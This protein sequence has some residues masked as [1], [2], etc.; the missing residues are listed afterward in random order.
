MK[1]KALRSTCL[2][3]HSSAVDANNNSDELQGL[4]FRKLW[5]QFKT[6]YAF[7]LLAFGAP[8]VCSGQ[9]QT[10]DPI[11]IH[12]LIDS[13][14]LS[15]NTNYVFPEK[16]KNISLYLQTQLKKNAYAPNLKDPQKLAEQIESD[17][18]QVHHDPHLR[19][20]YDPNFSDEKHVKPS[21]EEITQSKKYWKTQNYSFPKVEILPGNVGYLPIYGFVDDIKSAKPTI[22]AALQFLANTSAILID[23]RENQGGSPELV[24]QI[25]SY[26]F[27]EKTHMNDLINR[28]AKDTTVFYADPAKSDSLN[29]TM[30]VYILTSHKTFS[31]AEDF[32]YGMQKAKRATIVGEITGGGA[33]PQMPFSIGQGFVCSIPFARSYNTVTK[34]DWEGTGVIPDAKVEADRASIKAQE[35]IFTEQLKAANDE[36]EKRKIEYYLRALLPTKETKNIP[37]NLLSQYTGTYPDV[38]IY[39]DKSRLFSKN[40]H[41][42]AITELKHISKNLFVLEEHAQIEFFKG[43]KGHNSYIKIY[44]HDGSVFEESKK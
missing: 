30:P 6:Y 1:T 29:L 42:R 26:F 28:S 10:K 18:N 7:F 22:S 34:T 31:A 15:L 41:N 39:I 8:Y 40:N 12:Q 19:F 14:N 20:Q 35:L 5:S 43:I 17:I 23:L 16:A 21:E 33:H 9:T 2:F 44:L 4:W 13:L 11:D 36:K 25:E 27:K 3:L 24:S 32:S 38:I 37:V